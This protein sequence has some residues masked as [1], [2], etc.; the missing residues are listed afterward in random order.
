MRNKTL[1]CKWCDKEHYVKPA[2]SPYC[3]EKCYDLGYK[4]RTAKAKREA[5]LKAHEDMVRHQLEIH[6]SLN[7]KAPTNS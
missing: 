7:L 3:S 1:I 6:K 5:R 2:F 4:Q